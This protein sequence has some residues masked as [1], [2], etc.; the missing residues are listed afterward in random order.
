MRKLCGGSRFSS[1]S[2]NTLPADTLYEAPLWRPFFVCRVPKRS[3]HVQRQ[4]SRKVLHFFCRNVSFRTHYITVRLFNLLFVH[5][6]FFKKKKPQFMTHSTVFTAFRP[7]KVILFCWNRSH[8]ILF[9]NRFQILTREHVIYYT[10]IVVAQRVRWC[11]SEHVFRC[12]RDHVYDPRI[13]HLDTYFLER[14]VRCLVQDGPLITKTA[15]K[16]SFLH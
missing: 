5:L 7:R 10:V 2:L 15:H 8:E 12:V 11:V 4:F 13:F 9:A 16:I 3:Y 1:H 6:Y 14:G